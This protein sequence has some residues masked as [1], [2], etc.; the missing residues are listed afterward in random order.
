MVNFEE[1]YFQICYLFPLIAFHDS[2]SYC[3]LS[4]HRDFPYNC[5]IINEAYFT[6]FD[7]FY[8]RNTILHCFLINC[9][10][11]CEGTY[12]YIV[13]F[14]IN[15]YK[16]WMN[17]NNTKSPTDGNLVK[18]CAKVKNLKLA[19]NYYKFVDWTFHNMHRRN[20]LL[21][22]KF[23]RLARKCVIIFNW[24]SCLNRMIFVY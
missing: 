20:T 2:I 21:C 12:V 19:N 3:L 5:Q 13:R 24:C 7:T 14:N 6:L 4:L 1:R 23:S 10:H 22:L 9:V 11:V 17:L 15:L 16:V 8:F 18:E